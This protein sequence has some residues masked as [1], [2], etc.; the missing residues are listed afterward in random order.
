MAWYH[1]LFNL[2]RRDALSRDLDREM[3]FHMNERAD[4]LVAQGMS[5]ADARREARRRFGHVQQ[6]KE[7]THDVD[8]AIWLESLGADIRYAWR[9]LTLSPGFALVA[10]L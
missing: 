8:I 5:E 10:V 7:L 3:S 2:T 4:A 6:Q 9:S 1:R